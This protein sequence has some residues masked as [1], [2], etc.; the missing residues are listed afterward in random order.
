M[1]VTLL[2]VAVSAAV[3][4]AALFPETPVGGFL[5]GLLIEWPA[6]K[7]TSVRRTQVVFCL[8]LALAIGGLIKLGNTDDDAGPAYGFALA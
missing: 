3:V 1:L 6:R 8:L 7:L 2:C 5:R 4:M